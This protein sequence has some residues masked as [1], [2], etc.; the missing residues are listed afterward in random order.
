MKRY[1]ARIVSLKKTLINKSVDNVVDTIVIGGD[2]TNLNDFFFDNLAS[3]IKIYA[4]PYVSEN[5][6]LIKSKYNHSENIVDTVYII[7]DKIYSGQL[8]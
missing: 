6:N 4:P 7:S 1:K 8:F 5:I 3:K 2:L